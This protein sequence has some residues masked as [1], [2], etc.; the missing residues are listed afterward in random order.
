MKK[1]ETIM[2]LLTEEIDSFNKSVNKLEG[3]SEN[4]KDL[5]IKADTSS[6]EHYLKGFLKEQM[7]TNE[8]YN[9]KTTE[10]NQRIRSARLTPNWLATLFCIVVSIQILSLCYFAHH[11]V[12][13]E[14][15]KTTAFE[16]GRKESSTRVRGYF[17]DH[18]VIY[19]DFQ[20]WN[21]RKDSVPNKK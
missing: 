12:H 13:F 16:Q 5:K 14:D 19:E 18:P 17:E 15:R 7:K 10:L 9:E 1:M 6:I 20:K 4:F 11:F 8:I 2:E 3:L 21:R